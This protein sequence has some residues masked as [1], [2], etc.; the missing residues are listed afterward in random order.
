MTEDPAVTRARQLWVQKQPKEAMMVLVRR[1]E[2]LNRN[3]AALE[4]FPDRATAQSIAR[5]VQVSAA[6]PKWMKVVG[7]LLLAGIGLAALLVIAYGVFVLFF[8]D[9]LVADIQ[10]N[11]FCAVEL[12]QSD[13]VCRPWKEMVREQHGD[14]ARE[15]AKQY[16]SV[17]DSGL[18]GQCLRQ[19][20]VPM[21]GETS[22]EPILDESTLMFTET[23][24]PK[25]NNTAEATPNKA[26]YDKPEATAT[27]TINIARAT[28]TVL[29][30]IAPSPV[31]VFDGTS[32]FT[33]IPTHDSRRTTPWYI[34]ANPG[35]LVNLRGCSSSDCLAI[36]QLPHGTMIQVLET[37][38]NWQEVLLDDGRIAYVRTALTSR[39]PPE[40]LTPV[41]RAT[42]RP[43]IRP[44]LNCGSCSQM[45]SCSQAYSCLRAGHSN[46][47]GDHD[48]VPCEN[49]C[50]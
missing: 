35:D 10:L 32:P 36:I 16:E 18:F 6:W 13:K 17:L 11:A 24:N 3:M 50:N 38:E 49:L 5:P 46:L 27:A 40:I 21:P 22:Q 43:S 9:N 1:I 31:L 41:R 8:K 28:E 34:N 25:T 23:P 14:A 29:P 30:N 4:H 26:V 48:G 33:P 42:L 2:E 45:S 7:Y 44:S 12:D 19:R 15:C 47:D 39:E 20:G 37:T